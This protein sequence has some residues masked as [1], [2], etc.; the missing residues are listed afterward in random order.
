MVAG[1]P[2]FERLNQ[3]LAK[4]GVD[5][6]VEGLCAPFAVRMGGRAWRRAGMSGCCSSDSSKVWTRSRRSRGGRPIH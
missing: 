4:A 5:A 2:F 6:F 3:S 1:H